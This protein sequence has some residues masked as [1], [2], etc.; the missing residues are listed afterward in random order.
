MD[1]RCPSNPVVNFSE[2]FVSLKN[3]NSLRCCFT[4][5]M[6][7]RRPEFLCLIS[8]PFIRQ[9]FRPGN[10]SPVFPTYLHLVS[11]LRISLTQHRNPGV[12]KLCRFGYVGM[13]QVQSVLGML[14][15]GF[16]IRD[17]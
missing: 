4:V 15:E 14:F 9:K 6:F 10:G 11:A 5:H 16:G 12:F 1:I 13:G 3:K 2:C 8:I 17:T 7:F